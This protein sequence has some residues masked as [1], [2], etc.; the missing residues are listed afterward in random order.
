MDA[1]RI[2]TW[3]KCTDRLPE[4]NKEVL[5]YFNGCF[6]SYLRQYDFKGNIRKA[7]MDCENTNFKWED[8]THWMPLPEPP[9]DLD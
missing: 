5:I 7:W 3:I 4:L 8:I 1:K 9:N 6:I 2:M